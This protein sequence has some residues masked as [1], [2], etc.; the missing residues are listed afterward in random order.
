MTSHFRTNQ[1]TLPEVKQGK[2]YLR[3][4]LTNCHFLNI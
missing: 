2:E 3:G 4:F 1:A